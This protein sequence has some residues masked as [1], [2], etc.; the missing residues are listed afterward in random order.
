MANLITDIF[1]G[2]KKSPHKEENKNTKDLVVSSVDFKQSK[3]SH[4]PVDFLKA[5][6]KFLLPLVNNKKLDTKDSSDKK[7][8]SLL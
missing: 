1:E 5:L 2:S 6:E 8:L 4:E 7:V 3:K